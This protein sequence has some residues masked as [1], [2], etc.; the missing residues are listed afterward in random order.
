M[1]YD[2]D[3][4]SSGSGAHDSQVGQV[5]VSDLK[6]DFAADA[7]DT[8]EVVLDTFHD[9]RNGYIFSTNAA[10]AKYDAQMANEGREV[11]SSW[12]GVW[13]VKTGREE[14]AWVA[15]MA[16]PFR[17]LKFRSSDVQ[18][19][20]INFHR[21]LRSGIRNEDSYWSPLPRIYS[22]QRVSLAGTLEGLSGIQPG[23]N[24]RIKPYVSTS[25]AQAGATAPTRAT[26]ISGVDLKYGVTSGLTLDLTYNTDF[27]QVE[28]DEQQINLTRFSLF[29]PE[30][31]EFFLESSGIFR[32]GEGG[33][34]GGGGGGGVPG[35]NGRLN[36]IQNDVLF[37]SRSIGL[38]S[39]NQAVPI[40]GGGRLT[41]RAGPYEIGFL[42][43][44]QRSPRELQ[45]V[46][47]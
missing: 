35:T 24:I 8:V 15:E 12:D 26:A 29:F 11:N 40:L 14:T 21:N 36:P 37:F 27:S 13:Y 39:T 20:G 42:N 22:V 47:A 16:I 43:I 28:A 18:T 31:R 2:D 3:N 17:T 33:A 38:S 7:N 25:L 45:P 19:W 41:G 6:K 23:S 9:E 46:P 10:G 5:V 34:A 4:L 44:Q 32:F 1:L 30:K